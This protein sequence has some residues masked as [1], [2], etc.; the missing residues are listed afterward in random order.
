MYLGEAGE[1][2][3]EEDRRGADQ[4]DVRKGRSSDGHCDLRSTSSK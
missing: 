1:G 4:E 3:S 2:R